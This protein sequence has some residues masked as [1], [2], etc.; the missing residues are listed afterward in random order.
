MQEAQRQIILAT[1]CIEYELQITT[2]ADQAVYSFSPIPGSSG[3]ETNLLTVTVGDTASRPSTYSTDDA[4]LRAHF[5][6]TTK[7]LVIWTGTNWSDED[8]P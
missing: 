8:E 1:R 7:S 3:L 4:G 6:T 2:V 5:D